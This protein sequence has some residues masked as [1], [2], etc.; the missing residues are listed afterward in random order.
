[1]TM[2]NDQGKA[3]RR[4]A[5]ANVVRKASK[6][7]KCPCC[8]DAMPYR[9]LAALWKAAYVMQDAEIGDIAWET[10][11]AIVGKERAET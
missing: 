1:M 8:G 10:E 2:D 7:G 6:D 11:Q 4:V 5:R 3:N 9:R